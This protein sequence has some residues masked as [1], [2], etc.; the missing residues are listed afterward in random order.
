[1]RI[2]VFGLGYVGCVSAACLAELGHTILGV[3]VSQTKVDMINAGRSPIVEPGVEKLIETSTA[4]GKLKTTVNAVD[5]VMNS[6]L[7]MVCVGTPGQANGSLD[8]GYIR[9]VCQEIGYALAQK[10]AF[11]VVVMR[12]TLLPGSIYGTVIPVLEEA[13]GKKNGE[14]F[15]VAINPEF[16]REGTAIQDFHNPPFTLL[17]VDDTRSKDILSEIY[18]PIKAA[19]YE[20]G[21]REAEMVKYSCNCF[22]ALK[23][24]FANEI[25]QICKSLDIDSHQ[26]M[27]IF[28]K[29]D[30]LNLSPYYLR[31]GFAFGGSCLPKDL[32]ALSYKAKTLDLAVPM[33][34]SVMHSND[35]QIEQAFQRVAE[36]GRKKVTLLGLSF[37]PGTDDLRESP[38]V[39]LAERLIGRGFDLRIYDRE[40]ELARLFGAN[41]AYIENEIPHI[42]KLMSG[43]L[44]ECVSHGEVV[45]VAKKDAEY[46]SAI[47]SSSKD[48]Q[49]VFDLA[50]MDGLEKSVTQYHGLYW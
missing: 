16:L 39:T 50:R 21:V 23:V 35:V 15:A 24:T 49:I 10:T 8:L 3:D 42:S 30:K 4:S 47:S 9:S 5:A 7:S 37:K 34:A 27:E 46:A 45:I 36:M 13:S 26:V 29:D 14:D 11:H 25:G 17:G 12:S 22:H 41:R 6:E 2:S 1:L 40:V 19:I 48:G 32:R 18:R 38:M 33:L 43:S 31:P 20:T 28:C 44:D